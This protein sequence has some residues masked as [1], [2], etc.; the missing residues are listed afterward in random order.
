MSK[1]P[2]VPWGATWN[3]PAPSVALVLFGITRQLME[4]RVFPLTLVGQDE[5]T[6]ELGR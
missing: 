1:V 6:R 2:P 3:A 5:M 4:G